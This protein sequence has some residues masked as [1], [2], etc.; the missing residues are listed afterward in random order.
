MTDAIKIF[1]RMAEYS[2]RGFEF[3]RKGDGGY[4]VWFP[5]PYGSNKTSS[6]YTTIEELL[7]Y[8]DGY[9]EAIDEGV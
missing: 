3:E 2:E 4:L 5:T 1:E 6:I 7:A 8:L 9:T